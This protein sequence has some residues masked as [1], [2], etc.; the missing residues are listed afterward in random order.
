MYCRVGEWL[1]GWSRRDHSRIFL[2]LSAYSTAYGVKLWLYRLNMAWLGM[3]V[4]CHVCTGRYRCIEMLFTLLIYRSHCGLV[5]TS[6]YISVV[7]LR[8][9]LPHTASTLLC[10][11]KCA[12]GSQHA[13]WQIEMIRGLGSRLWTYLV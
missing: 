13:Y 7:H 2:S 4:R 11:R 3:G 6:L 1:L 5:H 12:A 8:P 9:D 10:V